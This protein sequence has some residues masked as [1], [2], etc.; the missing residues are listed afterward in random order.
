MSRIS[1][2]FLHAFSPR[3]LSEE[4]HWCSIRHHLLTL[5]RKNKPYLT[6]E[7][8]LYSTQGKDKQLTHLCSTETRRHLAKRSLSTNTRKSIT[9]LPIAK[10]IFVFELNSIE[11]IDFDF[12]FLWQRERLYPHSPITL[13]VEHEE[14]TGSEVSDD[15]Q[16]D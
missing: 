6:L 12:F 13:P 1:P 11:Y 7:R 8:P 15:P 9:S 14:R 16:S 5:R 3:W 10:Q 4:T 2:S